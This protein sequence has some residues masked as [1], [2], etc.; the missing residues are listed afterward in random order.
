MN[1]EINSRMDSLVKDILDDHELEET[2]VLKLKAISDLMKAETVRIEQGGKP[3]E[4][5]RK[6]FARIFDKFSA[7]LLELGA[8]EDMCEDFNRIANDIR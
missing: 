7:Q 1:R 4:G 8:P 5:A 2:F 6:T 3:D